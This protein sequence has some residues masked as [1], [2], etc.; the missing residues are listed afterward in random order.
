MAIIRQ[1]TWL[2]GEVLFAAD[3]NTEFDEW[4]NN[5]ESIGWPATSSR[6]FNAQSLILDDDQDT[7]IKASSDDVF[8]VVSKT[9]S[10]FQVDASAVTPD[11]VNGVSITAGQTTVDP[12]IAGIGEANVGI[13]VV[14][15]GSGTFGVD[16]VVFSTHTDAIFA[17]EVFGS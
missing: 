17:Y 1:K 15:K 9:V 7:L 10:V 14:P 16:G 2:D 6:D 3:L 12:I 5:Q 4:V 8:E 11:P 13:N